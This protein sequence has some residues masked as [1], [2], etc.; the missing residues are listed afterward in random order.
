MNVYDSHESRID[1]TKNVWWLKWVVIWE[2]SASLRNQDEHTNGES[3]LGKEWKNGAIFAGVRNQDEFA[4]KK[5][6]LL[7]QIKEWKDRVLGNYTDF[8]LWKMGCYLFPICSRHRLS[9]S[10]KETLTQKLSKDHFSFL[11]FL[12]FW[13]YLCTD[14]VTRRLASW[15]E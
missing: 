12:S 11:F 9:K 6:W 15:R 8:I 14:D 3:E 10:E 7:S 4:N 1:C 5:S 13:R 2:I